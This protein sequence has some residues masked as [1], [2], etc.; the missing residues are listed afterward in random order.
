MKEYVEVTATAESGVRMCKE[1]HQ[2]KETQEFVSVHGNQICLMCAD[3]RERRRARR[4]KRKL[5]DKAKIDAY[6]EMQPT[7]PTI[8]QPQQPM[9]MQHSQ[10]MMMHPSQGMMMSPPQSMMINPSQSMMVQPQHMMM[11][12]PAASGAYHDIMKHWNGPMNNPWSPEP[13]ESIPEAQSSLEPVSDTLQLEHFFCPSC[14]LARSTRLNYDGICLYCLECEQKYCY[15][16][17]HEVDR[18]DFIDRRGD[19]Q[20]RCNKCR[21]GEEYEES[22]QESGSEDEPEIKSGSEDESDEESESKSEEKPDTGEEHSKEECVQDSCEID[23]R[24]QH[25]NFQPMEGFVEVK[26]STIS[27]DPSHMID[28]VEVKQE[29]FNDTQIAGISQIEHLPAAVVD[30]R[31]VSGPFIID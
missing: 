25:R 13:T 6:N 1:C 24:E 28:E 4:I 5:R 29:P 31:Q 11:M 30:G 22:E 19:E 3:C 17:K 26:P 10:S 8:M 15:F 14:G 7:Q 20:V 9:M 23:G 18:N 12:P 16:G 27:T 2:T 21:E